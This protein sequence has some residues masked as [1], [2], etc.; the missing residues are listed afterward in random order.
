M[1]CNRECALSV[2]IIVWCSRVDWNIV[3]NF[4]YSSLLVN[5]HVKGQRDRNYTPL[6]IGDWLQSSVGNLHR[7]SHAI[8]LLGGG[9][10]DSLLGTCRNCRYW[11]WRV[12]MAIG[13]SES[14]LL[15]SMTWL[16]DRLHK[17]HR[18]CNRQAS[19]LLSKWISDCWLR[20]LPGWNRGKLANPVSETYPF[21]EKR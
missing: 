17:T 13:S 9:V 18:S 14:S 4:V 3:S 8:Y 15:P 21:T 20:I 12:S 2:W 10:L 16:K 11:L 6:P 7:W 19:R 1:E 5:R